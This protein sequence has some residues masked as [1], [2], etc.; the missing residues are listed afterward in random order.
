M[1]FTWESLIERARTYVDDDHK[2]DQGWISEAR[3]LDIANVE[4]ERLYRQWVRTGL[5]TP[6]HTLAAF[7]GSTTSLTRVLCI[8]GAAE[9]LGSNTPRRI[10]EHGDQQWDALTGKS[11]EWSATG[12]ADTLTINLYPVDSAGSYEVRYIQYPAR[13]TDA[14]TSIDLPF[15]GDERLVLGMARRAMVKES[16]ASRLVNDL[17][18]D[19]DAELAMT[20]WGRADKQAPRVRVVTPRRGPKLYPVEPA[21]WVYFGP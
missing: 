10:L 8:V 14:T 7:T 17:I 13:A 19:A 12:S 15:G 6:A 11:E 2:E 16:A 20:A 5:I 21:R 4:Y 3:W 9:N 18:I 1:T